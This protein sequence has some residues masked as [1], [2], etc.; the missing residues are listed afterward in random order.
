MLYC[1]VLTDRAYFLL[2]HKHTNSNRCAVDSGG[3]GGNL[4][5]QFRREIL[6]TPRTKLV[7]ENEKD[8]A[9]PLL[10]LSVYPIAPA[11]EKRRGIACAGLACVDYV[12]WGAGELKSSTDHV[13]AR[14]YERR[15]GG[16]VPN[17]ARAV[18]QCGSGG[19]KGRGEGDDDE[20]EGKTTDAGGSSGSSGGGGGGSG[21]RCEALTLLGK[22]ADADMILSVLAKAG[23]GTRYVKQTGEAS[24]QVAFLPVYDETGDRACI[25]VPGA[26]ALLDADVLLGEVG[27]GC[28]RSD[29]LRELLWFNLGY[30]FEL[31]QLQGGALAEMCGMVHVELGLAVALDLNGAVGGGGR[32]DGGNDAFA[33]VEE[34]LR[35]VCLV[36]ANYAEAV[37]VCGDRVEGGKRVFPREAAEANEEM[38]NT[39]AEVMLGESG[40]A[41]V[42]ITLGG[43]GACVKMNGSVSVV[44]ERFGVA[45]VE[46]G[47][48]ERA[49][50]VGFVKAG[51]EVVER[52]GGAGRTA[53]NTVGA[54][55]SFQAGM[56]V[57]LERLAG[58]EVGVEDLAGL[59][60]FAQGCAG[61]FVMGMA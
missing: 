25:V 1:T 33:V 28:R 20:E 6:V 56:L 12:I 37:A 59:L 41:M 47:W 34:A 5:K 3:G 35:H 27:I 48:L 21:V 2:A 7:V 4:S 61:R 23:V 51:V 18:M 50:E 9:E 49:V 39:L 55:D 36:H 24:T 54:G 60:R 30:P 11:V 15:V 43:A 52:S 38:L 58:G 17:T 40:A 42:A 53:G 44:R 13:T 14:G 31:G 45:A 46:G 19:G 16:S 26:T 32:A 22:D 8:A 57:G 10:L 29:M